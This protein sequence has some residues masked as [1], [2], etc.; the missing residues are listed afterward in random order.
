G[1][2]L[3]V[4]AEV[5]VLRPQSP[6]PRLL[7]LADDGLRHRP[8]EHDLPGRVDP[9]TWQGIDDLTPKAPLETIEVI[10]RFGAT[11]TSKNWDHG[12]SGGRFA[13][14]WARPPLRGK[15]PHLGANDRT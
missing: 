10:R 8:A 6:K 1:E 4:L 7:A 12:R 2:R 14:H 15:L 5:L 9:V 13:G 11:T 3:G